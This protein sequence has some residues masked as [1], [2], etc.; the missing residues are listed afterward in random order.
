MMATTEVREKLHLQLLSKDRLDQDRVDRVDR[1]EEDQDGL[2]TQTGIPTTIENMVST[3][4]SVL[5][6][7]LATE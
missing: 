4:L 6:P 3:T 5:P 2:L 7:L 1:E